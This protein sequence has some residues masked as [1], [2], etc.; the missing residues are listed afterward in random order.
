MKMD[1]RITVAIFSILTTSILMF[2]T[3]WGAEIKLGVSKEERIGGK[4]PIP[5]ESE[6]TYCARLKAWNEC[7]M[8]ESNMTIEAYRCFLK[9]QKNQQISCDFKKQRELAFP[10]NPRTETENVGS[11]V[12]SRQPG[13]DA[14]TA[15]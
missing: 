11:S 8:S 7:S 15:R 4:Y 10:V 1:N 9:N 3:S 2:E 5:G 14:N 6:N 12:P 13:K